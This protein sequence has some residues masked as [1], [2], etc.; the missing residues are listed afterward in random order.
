MPVPAAQ[1]PPQPGD[2]GQLG[3]GSSSSSRRVPEASMSTAGKTR[4]EAGSRLS[5]SSM[6]PVL[7]SSSKKKSSAREP[8]STSAV[9]RMVSEPP[10]SVC[11]AAPKNRFGPV[12]APAS[13]P[14]LRVRPPAA[15]ALLWARHS[16]VRESSRRTTSSPASTSRLARS[17]TRSA[18][19]MCCLGVRS[20][21]EA[22]TSPRTERRMSVTSSG[23]SSSSST[24][25]RHSGWLPA[26]AAAICW[27]STVLPVL[28]GATIRP[29]W[30]LPTGASRSMRRPAAPAAG[31]SRRS[32]RCGW[33]GVRSA[34]P[35]R[36]PGRSGVRPSTL[37]TPVRCC[38]SPRTASTRSPLRR[39][40]RRISAGERDGSAGVGSSRRGERSR[41][42]PPASMS[43]TPLTVSA[44]ACRTGGWSS[45]VV[46]VV[47]L[48]RTVSKGA[49]G[50]GDRLTAAEGGNSTS[51]TAGERRPRPG[52]DEES[53]RDRPEGRTGPA[54]REKNSGGRTPAGEPRRK[55]H[56]RPERRGV[57]AC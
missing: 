57:H 20:K 25:S 54:N 18:R 30:P 15:A 24:I 14:P 31:C 48:S 41:P 45:A 28:G 7:L 12:S 19:A 36:S 39:P 26:T 35:G 9:A 53:R 51:A 44:G 21:V 1:R 17:I 10:S 52:G 50:R 34:K 46:M 22:Y 13:T 49:C 40:W 27:S 2:G 37:A 8:V 55:K 5:R 56:R 32:R 23:R 43:R 47:V 29:R 33:S 38:R 16:R 11:R 3:G 4:R 6:L 42:L